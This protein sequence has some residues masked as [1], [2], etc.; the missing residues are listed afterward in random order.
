MRFTKMHGIGNDFIVVDAMNKEIENP[1]ELAVKLCNRRTGVGGDGLI[2][3]VP[4]KRGDSMM[5][6]I[7]SDGSEPEMCGNGV[8]C[9][10]KF[11]YDSGICKK[12]EMDI[13]TLAGVKHI[14]YNPEKHSATVDMGEPDFEPAR[15]PVAADSNLFSANLGGRKVDFFCVSMGNPHAVT[16]DFFPDDEDFAR[17]GPYM[18]SHPLLPAKANI[19]FCRIDGPG[20][21][22]VKVWERGCGP[23]LA[24]GTGSCAVLAAGASLGLIDRSA[25][26]RLP[27]GSLHDVWAD[28]N[29]IYMTGPAE[30]VY[31]GEVQ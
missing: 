15:I 26:I 14:V 7:N 10:A 21:V 17:F 18:E 3:M 2:L 28:D 9:A 23:T 29:H 11:L 13:D 30:T 19:E 22:T 12:T 5:R 25:E 27:G 24:C 16:F 31:E 4:S 20:K 1:N 8:R 6:I